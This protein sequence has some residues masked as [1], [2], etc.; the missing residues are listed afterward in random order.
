MVCCLAI[1]IM[2]TIVMQYSIAAKKQKSSQ[3]KAKAR[4]NA[5]TTETE[6][7][8][9]VKCKN[10]SHHYRTAKHKNVWYTINE[11]N[12]EIYIY[13][14]IF[15]NR[16]AGGNNPFV[17]ILAIGRKI[18][19]LFCRLWS[20]EWSIA[21]TAKIAVNGAGHKIDGVFFKQYYFSCILPLGFPFAPTHVSLSTVQCENVSS[22]IPVILPENPGFFSHQ[23]GICVPITFWYV[24]PYRI[25]EWIEMSRFFG[26]SEINVY[27]CNVSDITLMILTYFQQE[28]ILKLHD[29]PPA[30]N[31]RTRDGVK[32]AS[33]ISINDCMWRNMYRYRYVLIVDFDEIIV[34][35]L[36]TTYKDMMQFID[37]IYH[38]VNYKSYTFRNTYFWVGCQTALKT[39][40]SY[41]TTFTEREIPSEYGMSVKSI[42]DP[43]RCLSAFNHR[44]LTEFQSLK[45]IFPRKYLYLC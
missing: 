39:V 23:F 7:S 28:G 19:R 11:D 40:T 34:P 20:P 13:S 1:F 44:C 27:A 24:D 4:E 30:R 37:K 33:P 22:L 5:A 16:T 18:Q 6:A 2:A 42:L 43:R 38:T 25:V 8:Q 21:V 29:V 31:G 41:M 45:K 35:N 26:V 10:T 14:A 9:Y 36:H 3:K 17:R 12:T 15:D 32:I